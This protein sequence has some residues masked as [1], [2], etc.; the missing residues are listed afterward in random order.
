MVERLRMDPLVEVGAVISRE[1]LAGIALASHIG[2]NPHP[3]CGW[4]R[5]LLR[6]YAY[7]I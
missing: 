2:A 7:C 6:S 5:L 4:E 3:C 1:A